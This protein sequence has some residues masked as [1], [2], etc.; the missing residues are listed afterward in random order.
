M[1]E[2]KKRSSRGSQKTLSSMGGSSG[3]GSQSVRSSTSGNSRA[4]RSTYARQTE[5]DIE[6]TYH[7][8][9]M[10]HKVCKLN[11]LKRWDPAYKKLQLNRDTRQLILIKL[12]SMALRNKPSVLDLRTVKELSNIKV[13]D[14]W[15]RDKE[16]RNFDASKIL[17]IQH[18]NGFNLSYW[19]L[20]FET[21][22]ACRLWNQGVHTL[23]MD[24]QQANHPLVIERWLRKQFNN[25]LTGGQE[26]VALKHMKP[27]IQTYLQ[28]KVSSRSLQ[29]ITD[30]QMTFEVFS[31]ATRMLVH[32]PTLFTQFFGKLTDEGA[33]NDEMAN[34][35]ERASGFIREY[36]HDTDALGT[37]SIS[38]AH[39]P[40]LTVMEFCDFLFSKENA[41][42]DPMNDKVVHDMNRPLSHYWIAS[43]HNTY[44]TGDQLRSESSLDSY[45]RSLLMGCRCIE[46]DCWDGTKKPGSTEFLDIVIYHGYTMTSKLLLKDVLQTIRHYAFINSEY[47]VILS[48]EDNCSVPAQRLLAQEVKEILGDVLLTMP[49]DRDETELPSP[50]ALKRKIILK[51]K[52]LA[53]ESEDVAK[54]DEF[55]DTDIISSE[56]SIK[57]GILMLQD[58][59]T[60][61]WSS[62][63]F[64]L[65]SDK[66]CYKLEQCTEITE[67]MLNGEDTQSL[68]GDDDKD[69]EDN[70][71]GLGMRPEEM[72]V[73]EEWF[74]G[75]ADRHAAENRLKEAS[76][77]GDGVFLVRESTTFL[78]DYSLSFLYGNKVHHVR[79]KTQM[80]QGDKKYYFLDNKMMD[81]LYLLIS[82]YTGQPLVTPNFK[83]CLTIACPQPQPH[84]GMPWY[85]DTADKGK[86]EEL[87][88]T[89][90]ED[91]AYLIRHSSSDRN[92]FVLSLRVDGEFWHYRLKRDGR[93]FIVNQM[94]F[95]NLCQIVEYYS[96]KDFVRGICLK[97]PV[98]EK[99]VGQY[100]SMEHGEAA[101]GCYMDLKDLDKEIQARALRPYKAVRDDE[102]SFPVNAV[103]TVLRK[104]ENFW[105]GRYGSSTGWFPPAYVQE[106]VAQKNQKEN[107]GNDYQYGT[108][109][110]AGTIINKIPEGECDKEFAIRIQQAGDHWSGVSWTLAANTP[111]DA[112]EWQNQ[113]WDLTR[114]VNER[115]SILRTKEKTARI[116]SELSNLVVYCQA[117][118]F[119]PE[120]VGHGKFWEMCSFVETKL[121]KLLEKGLV[122][123]NIRQITRVY[124]LGSRITSA[125][126]NPMPMWNAGCHMVALNYQTGDRPMQL[127]Q[128]KFLANGQCGY[129]LKPA[130]IIDPNYDPIQAEKLQTST[131]ISLTITV[132]AGRH[133][134][135]KDKNKG[136]CSPYVEVEVIGVDCDNMAYKTKTIASNGLNPVWN[137]SFEYQVQCPEMALIRFVVEDGDFVGPKTDPF[138]GQAVFPLDCIRTGYRSVPLKNQFSEEIELSSLLVYVKITPQGDPGRNIGSAHELLQANRSVFAGAK[139][140]PR[141][142]SAMK[143]L[144]ITDR[145]SIPSTDAPPTPSTPG[146]PGTPVSPPATLMQRKATFS[147]TRSES[148]DSNESDGH[149]PDRKTSN[150][151]KRRGLFNLFS[152]SK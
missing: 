23:I 39:T 51:H 126:F 64:V 53:V 86:A 48:I 42:W 12:E 32:C 56:N 43:S 67:A 116:A 31:R 129:I 9:G 101:P 91:G 59:T 84:L 50:A 22:E 96:N 41:I 87:L 14:K 33:S 36:L 144:S 93:I 66:L 147:D 25:L 19:I 133:L 107:G 106:V 88:N 55:Q 77:K 75:R 104:E 3:Y 124:P 125:N 130:Y 103:I 15:I 49:V 90:K 73:T 137:N 140:I 34:N 150:Q 143:S 18:G 141:G 113:L 152:K 45:S 82:Y 16:I 92:V 85:S 122:T 65:F 108:I 123:F 142:I 63:V 100:A 97:F 151:K 1:S 139:T 72:H 30:E 46:L 13:G 76:E 35:R 81:T 57:K 148:I 5:L 110:L 117:V 94:V 80:Q 111:E 138:I 105:R 10:G 8:M 4:S 47:P 119:N 21:A 145:N 131:P 121:E 54:S 78:G 26:K 58:K 24:T 29:D 149:L 128:G 20:L 11:L 61:Q 134:S 27:F 40:S 68:M 99:D 2:D 95:E 37:K 79:I 118:P 109:E 127:N 69:Q 114:S 120:R 146:T 17:V 98:N 112:A 38:M 83:T 71:V 28:Y 115:V 62:H 52:K 60:H 7:A 132:I 6:K 74:H 44:L 136:I 70:L 102:L 135:R 89:V